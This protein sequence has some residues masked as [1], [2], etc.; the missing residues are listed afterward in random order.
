DEDAADG[1][2]GRADPSDR[3]QHGRRSRVVPG[4][5]PDTARALGGHDW[6]V[7]RRVA[8]AERLADVT[9]PSASEEIWRYSKIDEFDLDRFQPRGATERSLDVPVLDA[10]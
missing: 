8:A 3:A 2:R 10:G 1:I 9:W 6:L 5:T 4:F 7:A